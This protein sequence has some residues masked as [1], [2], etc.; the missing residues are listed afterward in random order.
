[1]KSVN[2]RDGLGGRSIWPVVGRF[3]E[4]RV[5]PTGEALR[6]EA[7]PLGSALGT[8]GVLTATSELGLWNS[9]VRHAVHAS[10]NPQMANNVTIGRA[11]GFAFI[12]YVLIPAS[13]SLR[14]GINDLDDDETRTG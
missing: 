10:H 8:C 11:G 3:V 4:S 13:H 5:E 14:H 6:K 7:A 1:M 2:S 12:A 9:G